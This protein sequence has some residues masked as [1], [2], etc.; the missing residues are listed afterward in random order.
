M[1]NKLLP[2]LFVLGGYGVYGQVGIGTPTPNLSSQLEI[3]ASDK[4]VLIPRVALNSSIDATTITNGNINSLLVFNTVNVSDIRVGYHYWY[5]DRWIRI[6]ST[7]DIP[8][9]IMVW[10]PITN[11]FSYIDVAGN[12]QIIDIQQIVQANETLTSISHNP[13]TNTI[14]YI[15]E[16]GASTI[17]N[18]GSIIGP[19]G[20]AGANG[21]SVTSGTGSPIGG[22]NGDT[23]INTSN[24][25]VYS[26]VNG[27][28]IVTG[29]IQGPAGA[30][31]TNGTN[32][33]SP[34]VGPNGNWFIGTTDNIG[35]LAPYSGTVENNK[36][37]I[38]GARSTAVDGVLV[39]ESA[40]K[41]LV[42]PKIS[43]PHLNVKSPYAG[44]MCYDTIRQALAIFD[45]TVWNYWK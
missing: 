20:P 37:T 35:N 44:M 45:G 31:G 42:L 39:L 32:G 9:N 8:A 27:I 11:Q 22:N 43:N 15:D 41:A 19:A 17:I 40:D 28:W 7:A 18:I 1:K 34:T 16:N 26:N 10:N 12:T 21:T 23:Y 2:L 30:N 24:G 38:I 13:L 25:D 3:V 36:Q 6:A 29:N 33:I 5:Q 14:T 4:G